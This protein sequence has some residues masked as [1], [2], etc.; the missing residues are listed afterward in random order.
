MMDNAQIERLRLLQEEKQRKVGGDNTIT[1][2]TLAPDK[3]KILSQK[4]QQKKQSLGIVDK[5]EPTGSFLVD[6]LGIAPED[7]QLL[8]ASPMDRAT[9]AVSDVV[10]TFATGGV[11]APIGVG[12]GLFEA[13]T[14][15]GSYESGKQ[16]MDDVIKD[17]Q[18]PTT[19]EEG[20]KVLNGIGE[21]FS[22]IKDFK[23]Y[24]GDKAY[25]LTGNDT[26]STAV[27]AFPEIVG[28]ILGVKGISKKLN[29]TKE[30]FINDP[31][32]KQRLLDPNKKQAAD[33]APVKLDEKTGKV[34]KDKEAIAVL[35]EGIPAKDVA[36]I[37]NA[38]PADKALMR[39]ATHIR[40]QQELF[41][42]KERTKST[43]DV[44][45]KAFSSTL[46]Q[47]ERQRRK[48]GSNLEGL[49]K[50]KPFKDTILNIKPITENFRQTLAKAGFEIKN[51]IE[52]KTLAGGKIEIAKPTSKKEIDFSAANLVNISDD[53]KVIMND[54]VNLIESRASG[55]K[56]SARDLHHIKQQLDELIDYRELG[57]AGSRGNNKSL[58]YSLFEMRKAMDD[59]L[60]G[61]FPDTYGKVNTQ[62]RPILESRN[63]FKKDIDNLKSNKRKDTI[64]EL[65]AQFK[66]ANRK[67]EDVS[68]GSKEFV[69]KVN[70]IDNVLK[71]QGIPVNYNINSQLNFLDT[72][73]K[74]DKFGDIKGL[75]AGLYSA[76]EGLRITGNLSP[77]F[78]VKVPAYI[79]GATLRGVSRFTSPNPA[80][81][82]TRRAKALDKMLATGNISPW[83]LD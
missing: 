11:T 69:N 33:L 43:Y 12:M 15:T 45:G 17:L 44:V 54:A 2:N 23:D 57:N 32:T 10:S 72:L 68:K 9:R 26:I 42:T 76:G 62:L 67:G 78:A 59:M 20:E 34:V 75:R 47:L 82:V 51:V 13:A 29:H 27:Y 37:K 56:V 36:S 7:V 39:E 50:S 71:G 58:N 38:T 3:A 77:A 83:R 22:F 70:E 8:N 16:V 30:T 65:G 81:V 28:S 64:K 41:K 48:L 60:D 4:L 52:T 73:S 24:T 35:R 1:P 79:G 63:Y 55:G 80:A 5:V 53:I 66:Q 6:S 14:P 25:D 31:L 61:V 49:V 19:S 18:M 40:T 21:F 74:L 46:I